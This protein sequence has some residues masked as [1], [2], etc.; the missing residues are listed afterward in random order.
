M[1]WGWDFRKQSM[2]VAFKILFCIYYY[3]LSNSKSYFGKYMTLK[4][5]LKICKVNTN[6][7]ND[8]TYR[9][10]GQLSIIIN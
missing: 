1:Q 6:N 5:F 9:K 4:V 8:R 10:R 3:I 2:Y 7:Y